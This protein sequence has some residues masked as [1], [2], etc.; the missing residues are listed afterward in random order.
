[1]YELLH[2]SLSLYISIREINEQMLT[3]DIHSEEINV[4]KQRN[5]LV[6]VRSLAS[7]DSFYNIKRNLIC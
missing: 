6:Y 2:F 5:F 1:M 7:G 4:E 3:L